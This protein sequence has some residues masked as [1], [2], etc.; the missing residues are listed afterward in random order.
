MTILEYILIIV[1]ALCV[2][3]FVAIWLLMRTGIKTGGKAFKNLI[4]KTLQK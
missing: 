1:A 2:A 4:T 3:G